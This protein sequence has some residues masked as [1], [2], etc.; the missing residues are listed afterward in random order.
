MVIPDKALSGIVISSLKK[1]SRG[2]GPS[3]DEEANG[4]E[5][6]IRSEIPAGMKPFASSRMRQRL[7]S[8]PLSR[9]ASSN[10]PDDSK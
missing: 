7:P 5:D 2:Q 9:N 6:T 8:S 10:S 3:E 4:E 1:P